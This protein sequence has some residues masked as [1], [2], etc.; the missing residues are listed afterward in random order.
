MAAEEK[1]GCVS[2]FG[3]DRPV[4]RS[5]ALNFVRPCLTGHGCGQDVL[6]LALGRKRG[7]VEVYLQR[8]G[9][10]TIEALFTR[11]SICGPPQSKQDNCARVYFRSY[12][13]DLNV[14]VCRNVVNV[15]HQQLSGQNQLD[16]SDDKVQSPDAGCHSCATGSQVGKYTQDGLG[17]ST[18]WFQGSILRGCVTSDGDEVRRWIC[19]K[20][21]MGML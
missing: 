17:E 8:S 21:S 10:R 16:G 19:C 1:N 7:T 15:I 12:L 4:W 9:M 20:A 18:D 5:W 13:P 11:T 14:P 6:G 2:L 3:G